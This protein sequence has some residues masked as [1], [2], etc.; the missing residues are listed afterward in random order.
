VFFVLFVCWY[1]TH[2]IWDA[3]PLELQLHTVAHSKG[4]VTSAVFMDCVLIT[5]SDDFT[6]QVGGTQQLLSVWVVTELSASAF[7]C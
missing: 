4:A 6:V 3:M 7:S 1:C 2:K 5:G